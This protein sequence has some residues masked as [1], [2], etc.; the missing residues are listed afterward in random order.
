[1]NASQTA[2]SD[3][4]NASISYKVLRVVDGDTIVIDFNGKEAKVRLIGVDTPESVHPDPEKNTPFG[5]I[6][7]KYTEDNLVG[8][9][10]MLE[11]DITERDRYGRLLAYVWIGGKMYNEQLVEAGYAKAYTYPPDVKYADR[12]TAAQKR[13]MDAKSGLWTLSQIENEVDAMSNQIAYW[14]PKGKS[15][16]FNSSCQTLSRSK[17]ILSGTL[18]KAKAIGKLDPCDKCAYY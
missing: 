11:Q 16:H 18:P 10:V 3:E 14:T 13:A 1:M 4:S 8:K 7:T 6:A 15:Y 2:Q 9:N 5:K 17:K 12:F